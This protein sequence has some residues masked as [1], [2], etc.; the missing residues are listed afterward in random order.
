MVAALP[1]A[2]N[3]LAARNIDLG[4][5]VFREVQLRASGHQV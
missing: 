4:R 3:G 1:P 5:V 2:H